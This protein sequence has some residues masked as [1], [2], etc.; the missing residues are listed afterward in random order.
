[1]Y[2]FNDFHFFNGDKRKISLNLP[3]HQVEGITTDDGLTY[4]ISNENFTHPPITV[5][6]KLNK[7]DMTNYLGVYLNNQSV[8]VNEL[9]KSNIVLSPNPVNDLMS[10]SITSDCLGQ[11]HSIMDVSGCV[12]LKGV[13]NKQVTEINLEKLSKGCYS[14][15]LNN[16]NDRVKK[17][18]KN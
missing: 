4:Y 11:T 18:I 5:S 3:F 1:M 9:K 16:Q 7:I 2:D 17:I 14:F 15:I 8:N 6:Q 13:L 12:V 10:V